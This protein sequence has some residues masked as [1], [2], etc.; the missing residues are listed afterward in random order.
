MQVTLQNTGT[1]IIVKMVGT[2]QVC[3][4]P[5]RNDTDD[6]SKQMKQLY[7]TSILLNFVPVNVLHAQ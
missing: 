4:R 2:M 1:T 5:A 7:K 3:P 6:K